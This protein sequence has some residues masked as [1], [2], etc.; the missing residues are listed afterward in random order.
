MVDLTFRQLEVF[1]QAVASGSF[2]S[3]AEQ[4][5]TSQGSIGSHVKALEAQLGTPLFELGWGAPAAAL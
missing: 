5:G 4:L 3:C 1:V 2:R